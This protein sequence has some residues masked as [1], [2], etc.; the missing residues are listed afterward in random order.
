MV[1]E[2][3]D[4]STSGLFICK[5]KLFMYIHVNQII[6]PM[7]DISIYDLIGKRV[8]LIA[9]DEDPNPI[10]PVSEG[11]VIGVGAD[12]IEMKWDNGRTLCLIW[13]VDQFEIIG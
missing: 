3:P 11:T 10:P 1:N 12:V 6:K 8:K 13:D 4:V 9:M 2:R 5:A 7:S